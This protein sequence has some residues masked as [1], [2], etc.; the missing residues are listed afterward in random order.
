MK[1]SMNEVK[2]DFGYGIVPR[3]IMRSKELPSQS[4][5]I[6]S[7]LSSFAGS[8]WKAFPSVSLMMDELGMSENTFYKYM[9]VLRDTGAVIVERE[10][11]DGGK[12]GKNIYYLQP[13]LK[14]SCMENPSM[15]NPS[16]ENEG[17]NNNILNS[18]NFN[19]NS[20]S[21]DN[22]FNKIVQAFEHNG[23]GTI[24]I[25]TKDM[26]ISL[27]EQ[28]TSKWVLD[29]IMEAVKNNVRKLSYVE[30]ILKRWQAE[31]KSTAKPKDK[32]PSNWRGSDRRL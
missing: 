24:N 17:T 22:D 28:Y 3:D 32:A 14:S 13:Y 11:A 27:T 19:S 31:G 7:Y 8:S 6:Y 5:A 9:K 20:R 10:S 16:M 12:F 25:T 1:G 21:S 29:A 26:L 2:Y 4:K 30:A 15:V 23:F 18:N